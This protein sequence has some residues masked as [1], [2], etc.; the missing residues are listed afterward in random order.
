MSRFQKSKLGI[1]TFGP[2][3][4]TPTSFVFSFA[5]THRA[6]Q[7]RKKNNISSTSGLHLCKIADLCSSKTIFHET[8]KLGETACFAFSRTL[9]KREFVCFVFGVFV[10]VHKSPNLHLMKCDFFELPKLGFLRKVLQRVAGKWVFERMGFL[11]LSETKCTQ[12]GYPFCR[13]LTV[14]TLCVPQCIGL[15]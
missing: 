14:L 12:N 11:A 4:R 8:A 6:N 9:V 2:K 5:T 7:N 13:I 10:F 1:S 15:R 3:T